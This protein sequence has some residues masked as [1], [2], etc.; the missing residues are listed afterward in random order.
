LQCLTD[1][2]C[3]HAKPSRIA[4]PY[5]EIFFHDF[6]KNTVTSEPLE[7]NP[8][9][10]YASVFRPL[11]E[12][13]MDPYGKFQDTLF[14]ILA[15]DLSELD[16]R[17]GLCRPEYHAK[18]LWEDIANGV[19]GEINADALRCFPNSKRRF[20]L[21]GLLRLYNVGPSTQL[22]AQMLRE[23]YPNSIVYLD[24]V[25][26]RELLVYIGKKKTEELSAQVGLLCDM[27]IPL[28]YK[29]RL[30][31]ERHFGLIG[32]EETMQIGDMMI[33]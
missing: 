1:C 9:Y 18:F 5:R 19:F 6:N 29:I 25:Y 33:F 30:F 4:N 20:V 3:F 23:L 8:Y 24:T 12:E 15:H 17:E 10:R 21:S 31:W 16:L 13:G 2:G 26:G 7:T 27:F 11:L 32:V 22:F 28:D 14:D